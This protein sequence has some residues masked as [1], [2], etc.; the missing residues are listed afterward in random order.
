MENFTTKFDIGDT[1]QAY[2]D[3]TK[4][5]SGKCFV[6][7]GFY[8]SIDKTINEKYNFRYVLVRKRSSHDIHSSLLLS[9]DSLKAFFFNPNNLLLTRMILVEKT[10]KIFEE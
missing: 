10:N 9:H 3:K 7:F 8:E 2:S 5:R 1:V 4:I 6:K